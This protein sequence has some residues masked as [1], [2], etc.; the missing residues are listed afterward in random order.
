M[1]TPQSYL[2]TVKSFSTVGFQGLLAAVSVPT[3]ICFGD[4]ERPPMQQQGRQM[5]EM[6]AGSELAVIEKAGH[7][8]AIDQPEA[9]TNLIRDFID[10]AG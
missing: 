7:L 4:N 9:F 10:R 3:L 2:D 1:C 5:H 6:I 8:S